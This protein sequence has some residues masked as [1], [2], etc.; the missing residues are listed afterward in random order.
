MTYSPAFDDLPVSQGEIFAGEY[1]IERV[2]GEGGM[3]FVVAA[4]SEKTGE[5]VAIKLLR[6]ELHR[7][8]VMAARFVREAR[9]AGRISSEFVPR[10]YDVGTTES[11]QAYMVMEL[12]EGKNL[13]EVLLERGRLPIAEAVDYV[14]E[15]LEAVAEAHALGIIHRD[16]KPANLF[17]AVQKDG[18]QRIKILDF[19]ISKALERRGVPSSA[20]LLTLPNT[21]LGSP[22][23]MSPEQALSSD[24]VDT[25]TDLWSLGVILYELIA[26]T[27]PFEGDSP[28]SMLVA[29]ST[30]PPIP[31]RLRR[32][33]APEEL[34][35]VILRCLER[36]R[37]QRFRAA[38]ELA[39]A[40]APFAS[41]RTKHL[42]DRIAEVLG[43]MSFGPESLRA[44]LAGLS[45]SDPA[46]P[47]EAA[48]APRPNNAASAPAGVRDPAPMAPAPRPEASRRRKA[49]V[50]KLAL[51][52]ALLLGLGMIMQA[53]IKAARKT[54][55]GSAAPPQGE[56]VDF[57]IASGSP[58]N[59]KC[60]VSPMGS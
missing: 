32:P 2:L 13:E 49:G 15:A 55:M 59:S 7:Y 36:E 29:I 5:L 9:A 57:K 27:A 38:S 14:M 48:P 51:L 60:I 8:E 12:L 4:R 21:V 33:D 28:A 54:Q 41:A 25:R 11:G 58:R 1:R 34:V 35:A 42:P 40:L 26:G 19:G 53:A 3:A 18:S 37:R 20:R 39:N 16:L 24:A 46:P 47:I 17:L 31:L 10:I 23:Y 52:V 44:D 30:K 45:P 22:A 43:R 6:P 50:L 56:A